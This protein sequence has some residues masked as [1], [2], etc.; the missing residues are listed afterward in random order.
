MRIPINNW[1]EEERPR[2]KL[3][4]NGEHT[5]S[6]SELLAIILRTGAKGINALDLAR[7]I[8]R[9]FRTFRNIGQADLRHLRQINGLGHAKAAQIKAAIEIGKRLNGEKIKNARLKIKCSQ[10]VADL[11]MQR[12]R[13]LKKEEFKVLLMDS[14]SRLLDIAEIEKGSVNEARPIIREIFDAAI[15]KLA[16]YIICVHNHP[17]GDPQ[18]SLADKK[19]TKRLVACGNILSVKCLDH[20]IF[21]DRNYY[22][23][24]DRGTI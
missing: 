11:L 2:E 16:S 8:L 22:S 13:D 14:R 12:M 6:D 23:F 4:N 1:P 18:P 19:F 20:I 9:E 21:G 24:L 10:D 7:N 15:Q 17:C 3:L 5:L